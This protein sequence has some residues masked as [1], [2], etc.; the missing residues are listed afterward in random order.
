MRRKSLNE[1]EVR[2]V[3]AV[4]ES[5]NQKCHYNYSE[6]NTF[7]GSITIE[8]MQELNRKLEK[9]YDPERYAEK[10]EEV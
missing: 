10:Y 6:L 3:L 5:I 9:W 7:M 4:I 1:K 2:T 8:E